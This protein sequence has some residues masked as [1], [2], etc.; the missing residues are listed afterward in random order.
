M[1]KCI[2]ENK[3][4][5]IESVLL[6]ME[7]T[8]C[9]DGKYRRCNIHDCINVDVDEYGN[10]LINAEL[11]HNKIEIPITIFKHNEVAEFKQWFALTFRDK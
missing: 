9:S 6:N 4:T 7:F 8:K 3:N 1:E 2:K 5:E 10:L 11:E